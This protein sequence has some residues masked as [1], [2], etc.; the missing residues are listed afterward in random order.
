MWP[1]HDE[2]DGA[3][4]NVVGEKKIT[5]THVEWPFCKLTQR[6]LLLILKIGSCPLLS[7]HHHLASFFTLLIV[8]PGDSERPDSWSSPRCLQLTLAHLLSVHALSCHGP[9][10][11]TPSFNTKN[12][13]NVLYT[14]IIPL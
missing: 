1:I 3:R 10:D 13:W 6:S 7:N 2:L 11:V 12:P 8:A 5:L 14:M 4:N 9:A